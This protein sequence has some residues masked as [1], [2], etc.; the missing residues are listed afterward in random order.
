MTY[1]TNSNEK[2]LFHV[3]A[4]EIDICCVDQNFYKYPINILSIHEKNYL[5][6]IKEL[7]KNFDFHIDK[8]YEKRIKVDTKSLVYEGGRPAYHKQETCEKLNADYF[9]YPIPEEIKGKGDKEIDRYR[10]WFKENEHLIDS[11]PKLFETRIQAVFFIKNPKSIE[12]ISKKN[13][14]YTNFKNVE[15]TDIEDEIDRLINFAN[16]FCQSNETTRNIIDIYGDASHKTYIDKNIDLII[17]KWNKIK[18]DL[19]AELITYFRMKFNPNLKFDGKILD[20]LGY[21]V[22]GYCSKNP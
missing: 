19:K 15:I 6:K 9:N 22:C 14:G 2:T 3:L 4:K 18:Y 20:A 11:D 17:K 5:R 16:E 7:F 8:I 13:S 21:S 1:I 10:L 12:I